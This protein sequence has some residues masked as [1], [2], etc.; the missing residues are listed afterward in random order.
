MAKI[1]E[2][3]RV[4]MAYL[5]GENGLNGIAKTSVQAQVVDMVANNVVVVDDASGKG[6]GN[7]ISLEQDRHVEPRADHLPAGQHLRHGRVRPG[8]GRHRGHCQRELLPGSER[9]LVL[10][11]QPAN[12]QSADGHAM[13]SQAAPYPNAF[14]DSIQDVTKAYYSTMYDYQL[15]DAELADLLEGALPKAA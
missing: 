3:D 4:N 13:A 7:E 9:P 11:E 15:T 12:R 2:A 5:L 10:D 14:D 1:P 6:T 8:L